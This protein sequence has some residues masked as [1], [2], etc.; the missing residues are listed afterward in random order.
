MINFEFSPYIDIKVSHPEE[1]MNFYVDNFGW[2]RISSDCHD[3]S[4]SFGPLTIFLSKAES[5][6]PKSNVHFEMATY[7]NIED[8]KTR[9]EKVGCSY[10]VSQMKNSYMFTD[11]YGNNFHIYQK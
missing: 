10:C 2:K 8:V 3:Q 9:L 1:A 5:N 7:D 11:P 6:N 4:L